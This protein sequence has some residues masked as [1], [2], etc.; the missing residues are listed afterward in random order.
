MS[1][2]WS[3][4][5]KLICITDNEGRRHYVFAPP[6]FETLRQ[7]LIANITPKQ[8]HDWYLYAIEELSPKDYNPNAK[9]QYEELTREQ[10]EIDIIITCC[11]HDVIDGLFG[12]KNE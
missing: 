2:D 1:D 9:K 12:V 3:L 5:K 6:T 10:K 4:R 7:K 8:L 11:I